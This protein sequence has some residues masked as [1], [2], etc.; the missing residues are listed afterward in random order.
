MTA[1][2]AAAMDYILGS[3][4]PSLTCHSTFIS[5][6]I[7]SQFPYPLLA[8]HRSSAPMAPSQYE[9]TVITDLIRGGRAIMRITLVV[10]VACLTLGGLAAAG[11]ATAVTRKPTDV[12]AQGLGPA[13]TELAKEF[14]FQVLYRT[15]F[16]SD[17]KSPGAVGTLTSDEAL[18]KVLSGTG[19]T[20]KYLDDKT[21]TIVPTSSAG[22]GRSSP[23]NAPGS[24]DDA[25]TSKEAGKRSS[26]DFRV[27]QV[28]QGKGPSPSAVG[29]QNS[30]TSSGSA[31]K[32]EEVRVT[33]THGPMNF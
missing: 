23:P 17:L 30:D 22:S 24:T 12:P 9:T 10:A 19:L 14:D 8:L 2:R 27:A 31:T 20:Y 18:G 33:G 4:P 6:Q 26:Q 7:I 29:E 15:E 3:H 5:L 11:D 16:V 28:D 32:L 1:R 25:S 21:V 13:L